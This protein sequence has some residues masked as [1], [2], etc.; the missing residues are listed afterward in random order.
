MPDIADSSA[1]ATAGGVR[2]A[3]QIIDAAGGSTKVAE[4]LNHLL[5]TVSSW[6]KNG[7]PDRL[8][9]AFVERGWAKDVAE[10]R[11]AAALAGCKKHME[12]LT[13]ETLKRRLA[14]RTGGPRDIA[15]IIKDG[16]GPTR[17]AA[18]FGK[19]GPAV[20]DW[21]VYGVPKALWDGFVEQ[22]LTLDHHELQLAW[23][24][25]RGGNQDTPPEPKPPAPPLVSE[26]QR[27]RVRA[28]KGGLAAFTRLIDVP[29]AGPGK[30]LTLAA[31]HKL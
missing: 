8:W 23:D 24:T 17:I 9:S 14:E 13:A 10:L 1:P 31:H 4:A 30:S 28:R 12:P 20:C 6:R 16:G 21:R 27:R 5:P 18:L 15:Q 26:R 19:R 29:G 2:T 3:A 11:T 7:V 25:L 22:G